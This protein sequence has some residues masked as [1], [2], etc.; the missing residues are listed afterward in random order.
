MPIIR[1]QK[2]GFETTNLTKGGLSLQNHLSHEVSST[3][4]A[5]QI[6]PEVIN[7]HTQKRGKSHFYNKFECIFKTCHQ[8]LNIC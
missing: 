7:T 3:Q 5:F 2:L 6:Q 1:N 4:I 8:K